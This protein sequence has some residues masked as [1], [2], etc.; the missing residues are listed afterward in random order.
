M[1]RGQWNRV[2]LVKA[3][4]AM[5]EAHVVT[6]DY[7]GF[8]D[9][10]GWPSEEGQCCFAHA[11][12]RAHEGGLHPYTGVRW[13]SMAVSSGIPSTTDCVCVCVCVCLCVYV[14]GATGLALDAHAVWDW[15]RRRTGGPDSTS[16]VYLYGHSLGA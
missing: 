14:R 8:A 15:V 12:P 3:L 2:E 9:S 6:V 7:R 16:H 11:C 1:C 13:G 4:A 10:T 5:L